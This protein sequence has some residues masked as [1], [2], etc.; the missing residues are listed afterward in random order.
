M[1]NQLRYHRGRGTVVICYHSDPYNIRRDLDANST[2]TCRI[3]ILIIISLGEISRDF[4]Y[5]DE[6]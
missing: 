3:D 2:S 1:N 4:Q 5:N 6:Y